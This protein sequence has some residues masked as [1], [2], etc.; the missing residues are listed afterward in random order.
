MHYSFDFM[1]VWT[2]WQ[3]LVSGFGT[4][5]LITVC[6]VL[7][8]IVIGMLVA[9]LH[10]SPNRALSTL[11]RIYVLTLRNTPAL[12]QLMWVYYCLP[13]LTHIEF[14]SITSCI[15]ALSLHTG[16]YVAEIIRGGIQGI[17]AGQLEAGRTLGLSELQILRKIVLPQ[18]VRRMLAPLVNEFASAL[19]FSS[20]VSVFGVAD[21]MYRGQVLATTTFRPLEIFTF[22]AIE[23][24][25]LCLVLSS[26]AKLVE[27][28]LTAAE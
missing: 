9:V 25:L 24:F 8:A 21:L 19:K 4:T 12:V 11:G 14:G 18:A 20:L 2:H 6:A 16:A 1:V 5:L 10:L 22:V 17:D 7:A 28:R 27:R 15:I 23:Y 3:Y 13:I 26:V